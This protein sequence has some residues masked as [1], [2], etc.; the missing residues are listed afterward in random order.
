MRISNYISY[1]QNAEEDLA[2]AFKTVS[3]HH[4][5]EPDVHEMCKMLASWSVEHARNL[6]T[7]MAR[8]GDKD[9][10]EPD[11]MD[12]P[13]LKMRSGSLGLIRDLHDL[14]L[15]ANDVK[16]SWIILHQCSKALR[17]DK[18]KLFCEQCGSQTKRQI[19]WLMTKI[20]HSVS[21][22]LTVPN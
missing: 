16:I 20:K 22:V 1:L 12:Y 9:E 15:M 8:Y 13:I 2:Q 18:L 7:M 17:D 19:E 11:R 6:A 21:Q 5:P 10:N 3:K 14:W 4:V